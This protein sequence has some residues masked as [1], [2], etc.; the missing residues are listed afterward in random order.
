MSSFGLGLIS[1]GVSDMITGVMGMINGTFDWASWAISKAISIG[2]SLACGGFSVLKRSFSS[3]KNGARNILNGTT[4]LKSVACNALKSGKNMFVSACKST[5]SMVSSITVK[6]M[7]KTS[8]IKLNLK[9]A[10][11]YAVQ[12]LA[13]Q[14]VN[15]ALNTCIN[16]TVQK[17]F[18]QGFQNTFK[19]SVCSILHQNKEFVRALTDFISS[20]IPKA[21]LQKESGSY[22]IS[23]SLEKEMMDHTVYNTNLVMNDL[24]VNCKQIHQVINI[25]SQVWGKSAEYVAHRPY[26]CIKSLLSAASMSTTIYEM[27]SSIPTKQTIDCNFVPAFLKSM[28]KEASFEPYDHDGRDKLAD[29]KRLKDDLIDLISEVL[30]QTMVESFSGSATSLFTKTFTQRLNSVTGKVVGN[31]LGR[32]ET[33]SFFVNQQHHH[34]LKSATECKERTLSEEELNELKCYANTVT[35]EQKPATALEFHV[36]TKSNLLDGK[37]IC[38]SVV[39]N[40]GNLLTEETYPGTDPAAGT[41][42]LVLTK[43]PQTSPGTR[44]TWSK[45]TQRAMGKDTPVSGHIDIIRPDGSREI[46]NSTNQNCLFHAVI[47]ATTKDPNDVVQQKATELR[48][49]VSQE[50]REPPGCR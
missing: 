31:F 35:D 41:I 12:E 13:I 6:N 15:T 46:V 16:A 36:L 3:V 28:Q 11:K 50:D 43:T 48:S 21:A 5:K 34:D 37:G 40:K 25:L 23:K 19:K 18:Q 47:Q 26:A 44:G 1:E 33:Q 27:Y 42:K 32:H 9:H 39:D 17:T 22:R 45:L 8:L 29:V 7:T 10:S 30:S 2:I 49:K 20:R 24:L 14:G 38:L 4:S